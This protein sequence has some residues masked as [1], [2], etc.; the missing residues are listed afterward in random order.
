MND[1]NTFLCQST[2]DKIQY[3]ETINNLL[4]LGQLAGAD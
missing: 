2:T 3:D 1:I 4:Q